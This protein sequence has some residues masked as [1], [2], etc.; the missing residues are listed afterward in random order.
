MDFFLDQN[1]IIV[2][3]IAVVS[4][5]MLILQTVRKGGKGASISVQD[6]IQLANREHGIFIDIR[7]PE[8]F[9]TGSIAQARNI[10]SADLESKAA[11][12]PKNKPLILVC[13][14]GQQTGAAAG[15]LRKLGFEQVVS[16]N[17]GLRSWTQEGL[18]LTKKN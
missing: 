9:K 10:P 12:L 17:G 3:I 4:G 6:A 8:K 2:V 14:T 18:P 1:N 16:I 15:K 5:A 7:S 13:D 11:S